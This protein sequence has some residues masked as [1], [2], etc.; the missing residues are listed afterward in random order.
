MNTSALKQVSTDHAVAEITGAWRQT[1][2]SLLSTAN[3]LLMYSQQS[4]WRQIREQLQTDGIMSASVISMMLGIARDPRLQKPDVKK[5]L[6]PSYNTLYLL[7]KLD[8]DVIDAKIK[9]AALTPSLTVND[10]RLWSSRA[11][12]SKA[13]STP[14]KEKIVLILPGQ[15]G[16]VDRSR[17]TAQ[18]NELV[19]KYPGVSVQQ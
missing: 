4:N 10:V 5:L 13:S 17:L 19:Q 14:Q 15:F 12:Q 1:I 11:R 3:L 9:D 7:T 2:D 18:L 8:D 6:P 16:A